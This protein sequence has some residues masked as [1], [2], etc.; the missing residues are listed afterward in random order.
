[1]GPNPL[2]LMWQP[3][4]CIWSFI[5]AYC[6]A[7]V[8]HFTRMYSTA[9]G[10]LFRSPHSFCWDPFVL[11]MSYWTSPLVYIQ[12]Q[13]LRAPTTLICHVQ[14]LE[15]LHICLQFSGHSDV[16]ATLVTL[17]QILMLHWWR[18]DGCWW[19][20]LNTNRCKGAQGTM[21]DVNGA[22]VTLTNMYGALGTLG[23]MLMRWG[24]WNIL[25]VLWRHQQMLILH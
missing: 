14:N 25:M 9:G 16:D 6:M 17:W 7:D 1:M 11:W 24:P 23:Q 21:A 19:C 5:W 3:T 2:W 22:M 10:C 20:T 18:F 13:N 12:N 8:C 15:G 4:T